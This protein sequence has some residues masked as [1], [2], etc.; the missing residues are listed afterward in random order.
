MT[1]SAGEPPAEPPVAPAALDPYQ[2]DVA[3]IA[4]AASSD[5]GF[6]LAGGNAL[7]AHGVLHRLTQ[8]VD[9]FSPVPGAA[10]RIVDDVSAALERAG[11]RWRGW[12][13][14][15]PHPD[16]ARLTVTREGTAL[17]ST[18]VATPASTRLR[19]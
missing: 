6:A 12:T 14:P 17:S 19:S 11:T 1:D 3:R 10:G 13:S 5:V 7:V 18:W 16:F 8:D 2:A 9:L 4:L 15:P